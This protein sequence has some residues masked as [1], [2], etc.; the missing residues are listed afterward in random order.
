MTPHPITS[1]CCNWGPPSKKKALGKQRLESN[2]ICIIGSTERGSLALFATSREGIFKKVFTATESPWRNSTS[3]M[4][5]AE[6]SKAEQPRPGRTETWRMPVWKTPWAWPKH[7]HVSP[8]HKPLLQ[9]KSILPLILEICSRPTQFRAAERWG[10]D[11]PTPTVWETSRC[12]ALSHP[13]MGSP[14]S[15]K[16]L[17]SN[18]K[19]ELQH[20]LS[21]SWAARKCV[22][23]LIPPAPQ[24][25]NVK[26]DEII[27]TIRK[28]LLQWNKAHVAR[29]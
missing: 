7:S 8:R 19:R 1:I 12:L 5:E 4:E 27:S 9:G 14:R 3:L 20:A 21:S 23:L 2:A 26:L 6:E 17:C 24:C 10:R 16:S 18:I 22:H 13:I 15:Q 28:T 11:Q 25:V 29:Q